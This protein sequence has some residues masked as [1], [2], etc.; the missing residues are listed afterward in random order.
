M[1]TSKPSTYGLAIFIDQ[2]TEGKL[3]PELMHDFKETVSS[4]YKRI[5][6]YTSTSRDC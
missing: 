6:V 2:E 3:E 1:S 5:E 4:R